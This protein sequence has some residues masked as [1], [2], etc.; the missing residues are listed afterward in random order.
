[1]ATFAVGVAYGVFATSTLTFCYL[2]T[3]LS[4]FMATYCYAKWK[5]EGLRHVSTFYQL[6]EVE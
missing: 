1:M 6:M 3:S 4:C 5:E 2:V